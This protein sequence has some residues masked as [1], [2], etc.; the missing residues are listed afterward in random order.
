MTWQHQTIR[1]ACGC[2]GVGRWDDLWVG[3][4]QQCAKHGE[5]DVVHMSRIYEAR[6][7]RNFQLGTKE[8]G[9]HGTAAA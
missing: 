3:A 9:E 6:P 7:S 5:T 4:E 1:L 2:E 8:E